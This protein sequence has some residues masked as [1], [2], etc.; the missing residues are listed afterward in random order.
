MAGEEEDIEL[1]EDE[2]G[3]TKLALMVLCGILADIVEGEDATEEESAR[4]QESCKEMVGLDPAC[5]LGDLLLSA[6]GKFK[7][8]DTDCGEQN[9][10]SQD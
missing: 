7:E 10:A 4:W 2:I 9:E 8:E 3:A 5:D 1:T 6:L